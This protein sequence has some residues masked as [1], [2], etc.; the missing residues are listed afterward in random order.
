MEGLGHICDGKGTITLNIRILKVNIVVT[1]VTSYNRILIKK[2]KN[3]T[4]PFIIIFL[5]HTVV[6]IDNFHLSSTR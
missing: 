5:Q 6:I 3:I 2:L 1:M 4:Y